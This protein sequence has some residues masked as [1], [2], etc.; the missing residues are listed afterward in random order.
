[1]ENPRMRKEKRG[2]TCQN[3]KCRSVFAS[4]ILV[5]NMALHDRYYGVLRMSFMFYSLEEGSWKK[6]EEKGRACG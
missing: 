3:Q 2:F 4:P 1:M 6:E 5:Q